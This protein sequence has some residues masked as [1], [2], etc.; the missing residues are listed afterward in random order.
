MSPTP[1]E[2]ASD[3]IPAPEAVRRLVHGLLTEYA[4]QLADDATVMLIEWRP[5]DPGA[6][7]THDTS[8]GS[9]RRCAAPD[10]LA[11]LFTRCG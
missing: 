8:L 7:A 6:L 2:R 1:P 9:N 10:Q 11:N 5:E 3:G 4:E